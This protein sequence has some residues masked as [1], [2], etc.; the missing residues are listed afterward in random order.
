MKSLMS[1]EMVGGSASSTPNYNKPSSSMF[2][3]LQNNDPAAAFQQIFGE[4]GY[5]G[6]YMDG[7]SHAA[8]IERCIDDYNWSLPSSS[9]LEEQRIEMMS[10]LY[11]DPQLWENTCM[12]AFAEHYLTSK[13]YE[14]FQRQ[15]EIQ[16][17]SNIDPIFGGVV[18]DTWQQDDDQQLPALYK[19]KGI[20]YVRLHCNF[21]D[22]G[23]SI[24]GVAQLTPKIWK[25]GKSCQ[26][27]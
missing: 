25:T 14:T 10:H 9:A 23:Y 18:W 26:K 22:N 24:G 15:K 3:M 5:R 8:M 19:E 21:G 2:E 27:M 1:F 17:Q 7:Y 11:D 4:Q 16:R 6:E 12:V 20:D 13:A